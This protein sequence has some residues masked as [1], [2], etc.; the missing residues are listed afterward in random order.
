[1]IAAAEVRV[2]KREDH[3]LRQADNLYK[4]QKARE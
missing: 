3:E 2:L 4:V 1:M